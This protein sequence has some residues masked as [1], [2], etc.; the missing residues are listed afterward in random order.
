[1]VP[2]PCERHAG[3]VT[4]TLNVPDDVSVTFV[5]AGPEVG[6]IAMGNEIQNTEAEICNPLVY[7]MA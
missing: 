4:M 7:P 6:E 2:S 5:P 1:M 3:A